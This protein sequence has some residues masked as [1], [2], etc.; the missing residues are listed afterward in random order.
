MIERKRGRSHSCTAGL[1]AVAA[2][3]VAGFVAAGVHA[4]ESDAGVELLPEWTYELDEVLP[5]DPAVL[6]GQLDNGLRYYVR[7][8]GRPENR[9][10]LRLVVRAGSVLE[11]DDQLGLAHFVEHMAFNGTKNF[12]K[13]ELLDYLQSIGMRFGAD[14]NAYTSFDETVYMLEVPTDDPDILDKALLVLEDWAGA[15]TLDDEEVEL[16]R[17]VVIE[18]WRGGRGRGSEAPRRRDPLSLPRLALREA[19]ADRRSGDAA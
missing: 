4:Q 17:G 18:E 6:T 5:E 14:V 8:N 3:L 15:V 9:A 1:L 2:A 13:A 7:K 19:A 12:E 10:F 16:E 11:D